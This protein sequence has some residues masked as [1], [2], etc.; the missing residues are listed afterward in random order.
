[1]ERA[2]GEV[3]DFCGIKLLVQKRDAFSCDGCFFVKRGISCVAYPFPQHCGHCGCHAREDETCV[4][5]KEL[6][7]DNTEEQP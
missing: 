6:D 4:L 1:M 5:F 7:S 3:F 2:I